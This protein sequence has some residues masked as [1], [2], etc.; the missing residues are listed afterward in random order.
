MVET[1]TN[2]RDKKIARV[3]TKELGRDQLLDQDGA[4]QSQSSIARPKFS[5]NT[6]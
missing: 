2:R 4:A 5:G 3:D 1:S 6:L